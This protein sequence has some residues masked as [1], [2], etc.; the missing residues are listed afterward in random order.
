[1]TESKTKLD[2]FTEKQN[3]YSEKQRGARKKRKYS[4]SVFWG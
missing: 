3:D 2:N 1:M 4:T